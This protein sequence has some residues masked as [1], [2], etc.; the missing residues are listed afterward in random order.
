MHYNSFY[1]FALKLFKE[2]GIRCISLKELQA[3]AKENLIEPIPKDNN[4]QIIVEHC[5]SL[6]RKEV[7]E[8]ILLACQT[9]KPPFQQ[10][11]D[12]FYELAHYLGNINAAFVYDIK[13]HYPAASK[14]LDQLQ[15]ELYHQKVLKL[16]E[17]AQQNGNIANTLNIDLEL[18][19][20]NQHILFLLEQRRKRKEQAFSQLFNQIFSTRFEGLEL[21]SS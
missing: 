14:S 16:L 17:L 2:N 11:A 3:R 9:N 1:Q 6:F 10:L 8:T 5:V 20:L 13:K 19:I 7:T 18:E 4:K 15:Q 21:R 12:L